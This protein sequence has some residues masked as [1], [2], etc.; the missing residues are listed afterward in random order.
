[1]TVP[2]VTVDLPEPNYASAFF[3]DLYNRPDNYD[4]DA[5]SEGMSGLC[6]PMAYVESFEGS[7]AGSIRVQDHYL[8]MA[9][10]TG[11]GSMYLDHNFIDTAILNK[12]GFTV[13]LDVLEISGGDAPQD[14]FGGFGIG[15]TPAQAAA[16]GDIGGVTTLR[17]KV[18]GA[19]A[20]AVCD[21][22]VDLAMDGVLRTWSGNQLLS[23]NPVSL[24]HGRIRVDFLFSGF[25]AGNKVVARVF[26]N[27]EQ[28][29]VVT[30]TW[31]QTNQNY[32]GLSARATN[33]VRMDNLVIM[34]F[35]S[36]SPDSADLT[37]EGDVN[38]DDLSILAAG[39]LNGYTVPCPLPDF[40]GDCYVNLRDLEILAL[41]W[42]SQIE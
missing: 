35:E 5:E 29:N 37:G 10:G 30:F 31:D 22:Y 40:T 2:P 18:D 15:L 11:M 24:S 16:A 33:Y 42:L 19:G 27:G 6:L 20:N 26:F 14:R 7:G 1:L 9:T 4:I 23:A 41:H 34:P 21:F 8:Q 12:G 3:Q 17:P 36:I 32:I 28:Q 13:M 39:W 38:L 25:L